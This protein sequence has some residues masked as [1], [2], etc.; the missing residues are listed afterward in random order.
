M[1]RKFPLHPAHPGRNCWGCDRSG[2]HD[3]M[4]CGNGSDRAP[5]PAEMCGDGW[6]Q[7]EPAPAS[8]PSK[9]TTDRA[10][11]GGQSAQA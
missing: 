2:A 6:A 4:A 3:A 10:A 1:A 11:C 8:R 7:W 9:A 5:H